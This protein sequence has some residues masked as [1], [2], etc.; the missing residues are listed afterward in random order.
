MWHK[1]SICTR[2]MSH[3]FLTWQDSACSQEKWRAEVPLL[4][5]TCFLHQFCKIHLDNCF[6]KKLSAAEINFK[7]ESKLP[8]VGALPL[9]ISWKSSPFAL[10]LWWQWSLES[11]E[12]VVTSLHQPL[13]HMNDSTCD[14]PSVLHSI[15]MKLT[16]MQWK[17][18][19]H[20]RDH[21]IALSPPRDGPFT[22]RLCTISHLG[23]H[24]SAWILQ[25]IS[26]GPEFCTGISEI[27]TIL[28]HKKKT[29]E[30]P[31]WRAE[32]YTH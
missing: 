4:T 10:A 3:L 24:S 28:A 15:K 23:F 26:K 11:P 19:S 7:F 8:S 13:N 20:P 2:N 5:G 6:R 25:L 27:M 1:E 21:I 32:I 14:F 31:D 12:T 16:I 30:Y 29:N 22:I 18:S 17:M 9:W